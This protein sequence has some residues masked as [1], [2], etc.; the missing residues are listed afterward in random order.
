[1]RRSVTDETR[2]ESWAQTSK[3]GVC[4]CRQEGAVGV[5]FVGSSL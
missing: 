3:G 5:S 2:G 4:C 1:M